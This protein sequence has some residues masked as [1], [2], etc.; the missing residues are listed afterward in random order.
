[1]NRREL[2]LAIE[3]KQQDTLVRI[4][5]TMDNYNMGLITFHEY[6]G[7]MNSLTE[8]YDKFISSKAMECADEEQ[9]S[10]DYLRGWCAHHTIAF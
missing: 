4:Q 10:L 6:M 5:D 2:I 9:V 8:A 1:M 7:Q 3:A